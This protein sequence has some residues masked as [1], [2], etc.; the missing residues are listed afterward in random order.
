MNEFDIAKL[1][2]GAWA[3]KKVLGPSLELLGEEL[4]N[5]TRQRIERLKNLVERASHKL[6]DNL[7]E[8]GGVPPRVLVGLVQEGT[9]HEDPVAAEYFGGVLAGSRTP[10]SEDDRGAAVVALLRDLSRYAIRLH[11]LVYRCARD[12]F[13]SEQLMLGIQSERAQMG[14]YIPENE[15]LARLQIPVDAPP[16][17]QQIL[18]DALYELIDH[19]LLRSVAQGNLDA[20]AGD[21]VEERFPEPGLLC[22]PSVRGAKLYLWALGLSGSAGAQLFYGDSAEIADAHAAM[23]AELGLKEIS[24]CRTV[25]LP[26]TACT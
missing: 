19:D 20:V 8:P 10:G 21:I 9:L 3:G 7:N 25:K 22:T 17:V 16:Q 11:Y 26:P 1:L 23:V 14:M 4:A 5:F 12:K 15:L 6:G 2:G 13:G 24:G 18:Y